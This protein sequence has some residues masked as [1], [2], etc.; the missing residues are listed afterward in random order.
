MLNSVTNKQQQFTSE[1]MR[2]LVMRL[3]VPKRKAKSSY[4]KSEAALNTDH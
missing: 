3:W 2:L 4:G 1:E